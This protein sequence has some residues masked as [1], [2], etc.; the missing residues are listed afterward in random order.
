MGV[1]GGSGRAPSLPS[2]E[3]KVEQPGMVRHVAAHASSSAAHSR[4]ERASLCRICTKHGARGW[5]SA[6]GS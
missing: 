2:V 5:T 1:A 3:M 4:E 6:V